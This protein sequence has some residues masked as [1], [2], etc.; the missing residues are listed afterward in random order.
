M[1]TSWETLFLLFYIA[2]CP[3]ARNDSY[4]RLCIH[5]HNKKINRKNRVHLCSGFRFRLSERKNMQRHIHFLKPNSIGSNNNQNKN[6]RLSAIVKRGHRRP[7]FS[8]SALLVLPLLTTYDGTDVRYLMS[9]EL[10]GT[11][12]IPRGPP[13]LPT[14]TGFSIALR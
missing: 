6:L 7:P 11:T 9:T 14:S 2:H 4:C 8:L 3:T 5:K 13:S 12:W 10:S 1:A